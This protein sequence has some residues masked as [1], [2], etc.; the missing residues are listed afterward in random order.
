MAGGVI[1]NESLGASLLLLSFPLASGT[2]TPNS[3]HSEGRHAGRKIGT[4]QRVFRGSLEVPTSENTHALNTGKR[5]SVGRV[6]G[7]A[8]FL[9]IVKGET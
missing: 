8:V 6:N 9:R 3:V 1:E 7:E 5:G 2:S 4:R